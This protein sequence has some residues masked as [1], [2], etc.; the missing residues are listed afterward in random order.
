MRLMACGEKEFTL[1]E[2][3]AEIG[4]LVEQAPCTSSLLVDEAV[5]DRHAGRAHV[6]ELKAAAVPRRVGISAVCACA[7][8]AVAEEL[9]QVVPQ[10]AREGLAI[11][12]QSPERTPVA[13]LSLAEWRAHVAN[14]ASSP[15]R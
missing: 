11:K 13:L 15:S 4:K 6:L 7:L 2:R 12:H 1:A 3:E 5:V 9:G 14:A 10:R 8:V